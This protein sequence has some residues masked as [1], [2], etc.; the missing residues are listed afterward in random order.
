MSPDY[1]DRQGQPMNG[2]LAWAKKM[3]DASYKRVAETTLTNGRWVST[4]WLGLDCSCNADGPP[5]IFETMVFP[6]DKDFGELDQDRYSTEAEAVAGHAACCEKWER[7][8]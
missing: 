7:E 2:T 1:Y 5:L 4:V 8:P 6:N 3:E